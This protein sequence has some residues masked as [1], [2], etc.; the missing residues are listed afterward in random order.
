MGYL[1]NP[2]GTAGTFTSVF[3]GNQG[4]CSNAHFVYGAFMQLG[5]VVTASIKGTVDLDFTSPLLNY[6]SFEFTLPI[7]KTYPLLIG[8]ITFD[9]PNNVNGFVT[10]VTNNRCNFV[11]NDNTLITNVAFYAVFQYQIY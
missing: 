5:S 11:S 6:G 3:S 9:V 8:T 10:D 4:A 2:Q 1:I 7:P